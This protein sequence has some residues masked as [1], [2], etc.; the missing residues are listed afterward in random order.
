MVGLGHCAHF[1]SSSIMT[2]FMK[3][4]R[5]K[6]AL[7]TFYGWVWRATRSHGSRAMFKGRLSCSC[8][9][10]IGQ[11]KI[12]KFYAVELITTGIF[13][14]AFEK[15]VS[16]AIWLSNMGK[17]LL[18]Q[19]QCLHLCLVQNPADLN[20]VRLKVYDTLGHRVPN[21]ALLLRTLFVCGKATHVVAQTSLSQ[22]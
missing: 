14:N 11:A 21:V 18:K 5:F 17:Q 7:H 16:P 19:F 1:V 9:C 22:P 3:G 12:V 15:R 10:W 8:D 2:Q 4:E 20:S 6:R 13:S